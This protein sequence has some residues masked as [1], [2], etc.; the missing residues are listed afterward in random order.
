MTQ[1]FRKLALLFYGFFILAFLGFLAGR[2]GGMDYPE[3]S[4]DAVQVWSSVYYMYVLLSIPLAFYLFGRQTKKWQRGEAVA[5]KHLDAYFRISLVRL[6]LLGSAMLFGCLLLSFLF[7]SQSVL[8]CTVIAALALITC[9]PGP[10]KIRRELDEFIAS[11][12]DE[13]FDEEENT[14]NQQTQ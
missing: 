8:F 4:K 11:E 3:L 7:Y 1:I 5:G 10:A 2:Y 14:D 13:Q 12:A 9:L 6:L